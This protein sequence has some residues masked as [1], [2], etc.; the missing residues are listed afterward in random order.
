MQIGFMYDNHTFAKVGDSQTPRAELLSNALE[1]FKYD[2]CGMLFARWTDS[3]NIRR[4]APVAH[5]KLQED[6]R[7]GVSA[8]DVD[9]FLDAV[10]EE[11][12]WVARG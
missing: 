1:L 5:G 2:G 11:I 8:A 12:N 3:A 6:G 7:Y 9:A 4:A 10:E